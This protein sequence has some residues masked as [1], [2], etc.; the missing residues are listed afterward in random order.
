[1]VKPGRQNRHHCWSICVVHSPKWNPWFVCLTPIGIEFFLFYFPFPLWL[2]FW[3]EDIA[4]VKDNVCSYFHTLKF[5]K[6]T[7]LPFMFSTLYSVF[8]DVVK[9][10]LWYVMC[11]ICI[12]VTLW[13]YTT[14]VTSLFNDIKINNWRKFSFDNSS[15]WVGFSSLH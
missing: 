2:N 10:G 11:T 7:R 13:K 4:N 1:M 9:H 14:G 12:F 3:F 8:R 5:I 15:K 6:N